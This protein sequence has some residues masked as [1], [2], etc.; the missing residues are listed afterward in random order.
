MNTDQELLT[1]AAT[2]LGLE[3]E[4]YTR[5]GLSVYN[6]KTGTSN[7][8]FNPLENDDQAFTLAIK[9]GLRVHNCLIIEGVIVDDG[10]D[11]NRFRVVKHYEDK[12]DAAEV[13]RRAIVEALILKLQR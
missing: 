6:P 1:K 13:A 7:N 8:Y 12:F 11:V 4:R 3:P 9:H 10:L 2:L 5:H